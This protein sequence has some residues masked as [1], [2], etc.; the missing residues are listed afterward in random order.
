[1][2]GSGSSCLFSSRPLAGH[3]GHT[4]IVER[5]GEP[6]GRRAFYEALR[7]DPSVGAGLAEIV[8]ATGLPAVAWE[9]APVSRARAAEPMTQVV[10]PHPALARALPD[11]QPFAEHIASGAG[12]AEVRWFSNF[13]AD[14]K[15]VVPCAPR[16]ESDYGHLVTFLRSA[17]AAQREALWRLVGRLVCEHLDA[18]DAPLWVSTAGMAVSWVHVR[19]DLRPK[20][21]RTEAFRQP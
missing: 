2:S 20:Y 12:T 1:M 5:D 17:P 21:Y 3:A 15:L 8:L 10:L 6:L 9:T 16:A 19:L 11:P 4:L 18:S 14:A 13:V 7:D